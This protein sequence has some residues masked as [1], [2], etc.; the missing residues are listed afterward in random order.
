MRAAARIVSAAEAVAA[1][2]SGATVAVGGFVG[3]G[4]PEMLT[5]ALENHFLKTGSPRDLTLVYCAGQGDRA[6]RGLNH[7]AHAGLLKRVVG[8]HWNLAP[9]LGRMALANEI[10][11]YNFP[12][13]VLCVLL[14]EIAGKRPGVFTKIG[15]NTFIDPANTGG[16]LNA[17]TTEPLVERVRLDGED[18]LRYRAFP[19]HVGLIRATSADARGNLTLEREALIGEMLPIAQAA[20]NHGGIVIAQVE[21][22]IGSITDPKTVRVPGILVDFIVMSDGKQHDQTFAEPFNDAYVS[23]G[24]VT[25][26]FKPMPLS[27]R[28][29][30]GRRVLREIRAGDIVN[31][32]IGVPEAVASVAAETGRLG[33][34]TLTLESGPIGGVPAGGLSFGCSAHPEAVID[35]P[36]QF[37]FYDGGGL[38]IAVLGALEVDAEGNVNVSTLGGGRFAGVG[39]FVNITQNAKRVVFACAFRTDGLEVDVHDGALRVLREGR[40]AKFVKR[41]AQVC[42]HGP[43]ALARGQQ[44]LYVTERAVFELGKD[45]L[46]LRE[47]APG[48]GLDTD[49]LEKM[50]F[51]VRCA[52]PSPMPSECFNQ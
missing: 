22:V 40:Q 52:S 26:A 49:V 36:S 4:H 45:G 7:L 19:V 8:G 29:I 38:D 34:F 1:I 39:G 30:I 18:W 13:G 24:D 43:S 21:R 5:A 41:V 48:V 23:R 42:F 47:L 17:R 25:D 51:P 27:E 37:D 6:E 3:A 14:R 15:L 35:Q 31:L 32:G 33:E 2:P 46:Q 12:Q 9:K 11:A 20:K 28:K 10:E 16:R 44:V 50:E